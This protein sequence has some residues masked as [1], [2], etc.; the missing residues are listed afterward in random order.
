MMPFKKISLKKVKAFS[1]IEVLMAVVILALI[2][3]PIL[4]TIFSSIAINR[5]SKELMAATDVA[6]GIIECCE[7]SNYKYIDQTLTG[8]A[9]FSKLDYFPL[10]VKSGTTTFSKS[11]S[12]STDTWKFSNIKYTSTT[13]YKGYDFDV[14]ID[15]VKPATTTDTYYVYDVFVTVYKFNPD[16]GVCDGTALCQIKGSVLNE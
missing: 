14:K 1:L 12:G 3:V 13:D 15:F 8:G 10:I 4:Q 2:S 6:N 5:R 7:K 9:G 11:T 16:P